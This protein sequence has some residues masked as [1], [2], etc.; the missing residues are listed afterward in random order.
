MQ[1][2]RWNFRVVER[3]ERRE[4]FENDIAVVFDDRATN[5]QARCR[6]LPVNEDNNS[7]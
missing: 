5:F 3:F 2:R 7:L 6:K 4:R 1:P